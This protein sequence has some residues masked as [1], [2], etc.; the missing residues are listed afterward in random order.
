MIVQMKT[1]FPAFLLLAGCAAFAA[2]PIEPTATLFE[3]DQVKV[4]R[5]LEKAHVKG[6]FHEHKMDRIPG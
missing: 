3:N 6:K 2:I 4:I 5:A 1:K